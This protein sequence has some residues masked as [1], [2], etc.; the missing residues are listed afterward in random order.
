M[1][2]SFVLGI[3][4]VQ[5]QRILAEKRLEHI[6]VC[7]DDGQ[8]QGAPEG[9]IAGELVHADLDEDFGGLRLLL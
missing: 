4:H 6:L 5:V 9:A 1:Q 3:P 2:R 7:L 8:V